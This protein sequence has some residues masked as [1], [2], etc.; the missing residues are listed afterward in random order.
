MAGMKSIAFL[1][2]D[3][4]FW[5]WG[6]V[7]ESA[8]RAVARAQQNGHVVMCNTGRAYSEVD[9]LEPYGLNGGCFA[10]GADVRV[11]G[12]Q[13]VDERMDERTSRCLVELF[14]KWGLNFSLEGR[15]RTFAH[16]DDEEAFWKK[17]D[18]RDLSLRD[19]FNKQGRVENM[20]SGDYAQ[21]YKF[22]V[23]DATLSQEQQAELPDGLVFTDFVFAG[24][25]TKGHINKATAMETVR[26]H[27]QKKTGEP[28]RTI[29]FGDS[30][31]DIPMLRAADV[32]VC[33]GNGNQNAKDA[34]DYITSAVDDD[35]LLHAFEHLG[36]V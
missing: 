31:N 11:D 29:A 16:F 6:N 18:E 3:G 24:E 10:A 17:A 4:T 34:A 36:L 5:Q 12:M 32:G 30:D 14:C 20:G 2:L 19:F 33:M 21:V 7:P 23:F 1:D 13:L 26:S 25:I 22:C 9:G 27:M 28:W 8:G 15:H 35:G